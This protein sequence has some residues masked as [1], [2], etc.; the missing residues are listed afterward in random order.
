MTETSRYD[1]RVG[2]IDIGSN[3]VRL[4]IAEANGLNRATVQGKPG[5]WS[6]PYRVIVDEK[7]TTRLATGM[8]ITGRLDARAMEQSAYAIADM[9]AVS[10]R[11]GV[12]GEQLLVVAT[13]AVREAKNREEFCELIRRWSG[14]RV[15]IVSAKREAKLAFRSVAS[16]FDL[17]EIETAGATAKQPATDGK[18]ELKHG[19]LAVI[20]LGGGSTEVILTGRGKKADKI[21]RIFALPIGAVRI[22]ERFGGPEAS[23]GGQFAAMKD[24]TKRFVVRRVWEV[25]RRPLL[26]IGTGGTVTALASMVSGKSGSAVH[27]QRLSIIDVRATLSDLRVMSL[28]DRQHVPGLSK[29]R[30]DLVVGGLIILEAVMARLGCRELIASTGGIRDGVLLGAIERALPATD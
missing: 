4:V 16:G 9:R 25:D 14:L 5:V 10:Q 8:D 18:G 27:G 15:R 22:T 3:S 23:T 17:P 24:W 12:A 19:G 7:A 13:C 21:K 26:M 2:V 30:A 11:H 1:E 20:D 6:S 28:A 29:D